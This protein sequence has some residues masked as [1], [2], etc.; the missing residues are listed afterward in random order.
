MAGAADWRIA[1]TYLESCNCEAICPCRRI[2]GVPGGDSTYGVCFGA[3]SWLVTDGAYGDE[4][5]D[6]LAAV[7]L[8][9]HYY[10]AED[11]SPWT[12]S[13]FLDG[14]ATESQHEALESILLGRVGGPVEQF[15][16]ARKPS[17]LADVR[18]ARIEVDHRARRKWF[19]VEDFLVV[20]VSQP[21]ETEES[22]SCVV[23]GHARPGK[24]YYADLLRA[25]LPEAS[26]ELSGNC[27]FLTDFD[28]RSS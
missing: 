7:L 1:G 22:V 14:R 11:G 8:L 25:D 26:W 20:R 19:R 23:P 5:L 24:E 4:R 15:P 21:V 27:A 12:F 13:L 18:S 28:Y 10:D 2:G 17:H 9:H 6:G 3:L 16:W